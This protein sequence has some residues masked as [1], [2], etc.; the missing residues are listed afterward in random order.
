MC[1]VLKK[2]QNAPKK[3]R[4]L[5]WGGVLSFSW[6][7]KGGRR[8]DADRP[9]VRAAAAAEQTPDVTLS[10]LSQKMDLAPQTLRQDV[11][12]L[13]PLFLLCIAVGTAVAAALILFFRKKTHK[14]H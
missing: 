9:T 14:V 12:A 2:L 8:D 6:T 11:N 5:R 10:A 1:L 7:K 13:M 3:M 4:F